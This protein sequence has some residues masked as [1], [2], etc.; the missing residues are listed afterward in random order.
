MCALQFLRGM[1]GLFDG[2]SHFIESTERSAG[3]PLL[4]RHRSMTIPIGGGVRGVCGEA[5]FSLVE[6]V[7]VAGMVACLAAGVA[8]VFGMSARANHVARVQ[9]LAA[10][11]AAQKM[12][13]LRSLTWAHAPGGEPVSDVSTDLAADPPSG[14]G[15][16]LRPSPAGSLEI[17]VPSYV[18]Y[19]GAG[20]ATV[21]S[22]DA[23]AYVRR[24]SVAAL[25]SDPDNLLV[26][27]VRVVTV[28]G[29]DTRLV[30]LKARRP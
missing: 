14:G 15:T 8:Q 10:V 28:A 27:Q 29:G 6:V 26:L 7:L 30:S 24:W 3:G 11:L 13:Q 5:G 1:A 2:T 4:A 19:L 25:A 23:A 20:G 22:R 18:D 17:D 9:T 12:E 16:G 21:P